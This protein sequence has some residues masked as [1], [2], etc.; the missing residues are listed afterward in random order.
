MPGFA[1]LVGW[2]VARTI[3]AH[4]AWDIRAVR[5]TAALVLLAALGFGVAL[6]VLGIDV[7]GAASAAALAGFGVTGA[8][9]V[10]AAAVLALAAD[11]G[12]R[13]GQIQRGPY[14]LAL[15]Y[16]LLL[17]L[18]ASAVYRVVDGWQ[19][20]PAIGRAIGTDSAGDPL[21]LAAPDETTRA[22]IDMYA[23]TDVQLI[24]S[25]MDE[26]AIARLKQLTGAELHAF[27]VAQWPGRETTPTVQRLADA[28]GIKL[29]SAPAERA[30]PAWVA[31][32][33]LKVVHL[34]ALPNGRRYALLQRAE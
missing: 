32:A 14:S 2:W 1:L 10:I 24:G 19:E 33:G 26:R 3:R 5:V 27:V 25:P 8:L 11:A 21:I 28:L 31:A 30:A 17:A 4:D 13:R 6:V 9:G 12:A 29:D 20:L 16:C 22:F 7:S 18:P 15:A 23:R 34:Y